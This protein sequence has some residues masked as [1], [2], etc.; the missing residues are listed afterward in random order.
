M[1]FHLAGVI[2]SGFIDDISIAYREAA[3]L[4]VPIWSGGGTH[5]KVIEALMYGRTCVLSKPAYKGFEDHF[6]RDIAVSVASD[7]EQMTK[8]CVA[9][10]KTPEKAA[11]MG[12]RRDIEG[13]RGTLYFFFISTD[14]PQN[15]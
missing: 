13:R 8:Y 4:A 1:G 10:L 6:G 14:S 7:A 3:F 5:I 9:L 12:A 2:V 11:A 15:C